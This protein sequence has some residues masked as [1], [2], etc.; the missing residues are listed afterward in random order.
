MSS[1]FSITQAVNPPRA[2]YLDYPL[3][4]TAGKLDRDDQRS[5]MRAT[6]RA[7]ER[8]QPDTGIVTL[9]FTWHADDSWKERVMRPQK[10]KGAEASQHADDRVARFDTPQYQS[11]SDAEAADPNCPTCIFIK[12][13]RS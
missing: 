4:H 12:S 7:F 8:A 5:V 2:V 13:D 1:A 9:P 11:E 10:K 6:L 3:G